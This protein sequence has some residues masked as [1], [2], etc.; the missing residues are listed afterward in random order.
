MVWL[1]KERPAGWREFL[2]AEEAEIVGALEKT[3]ADLRAE[4][5]DIAGQVTVFRQRAYG[6]KRIAARR[7]SAITEQAGPARTNAAVPDPE[8]FPAQGAGPVD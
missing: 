2:T 5:A 4:G 6:R 1:A 7:L 3:T 8:S